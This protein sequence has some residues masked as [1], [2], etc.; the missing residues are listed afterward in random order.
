MCG[1]HV[2][3]EAVNNTWTKAVGYLPRQKLVSKRKHYWLHI[4]TVYDFQADELFTSPPYVPW[5]KVQLMNMLY[6]ALCE[7]LVHSFPS[8]ASKVITGYHFL[9]LWKPIFWVSGPHQRTDWVLK[10]GGSLKHTFALLV[11]ETMGSNKATTPSQHHQQ[12]LQHQEEEITDNSKTTTAH[13]SSTIKLIRIHY[14]Q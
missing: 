10:R 14:H 8:V 6:F 13:G 5:L 12:T 3:T 11:P 9:W 4:Y 7:I 2:A 1:K